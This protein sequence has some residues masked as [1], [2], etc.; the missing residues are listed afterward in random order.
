MAPATIKSLSGTHLSVKPVGAIGRKGLGF[1][2]VYTV[3]RTPCVFSQDDGLI[4]CPDRASAWLQEHGITTAKVPYQWLPFWLSRQAQEKDD[5]FLASLADMRTVVKLPVTKPAALPDVIEQLRALPGHS[6]LTF[7]KLKKLEVEVTEAKDKSFIVELKPRESHENEW[8]IE[9]TRQSQ[10][11]HW[12]LTRLPVTPPPEALA[13]FEDEDDRERAAKATILAATPLGEDNQVAPAPESMRL[14]VYYSTEEPAPVPLLLHAD[15]IVKSDRTRV[16]ALEASPFNSWMGERLAGHIVECV[17]QWYSAAA[18]AANLRLL[19]PTANLDDFPASARLWK[20]IETQAKALLRLPDAKGNRVLTL[21][22]ACLTATS[23]AP[24]LARQILSRCDYAARLVHLSLDRD[25]GAQLVLDKLGCTKLTDSSVFGAIAGATPVLPNDAEWLWTCWH[26]VA[27]WAVPERKSDWSRERKEQRLSLLRR[28][29]MLPIA[30]QTLSTQSLAGKTVTWREDNLQFEV[31]EWLPLLFIDDWLRDRVR[32]LAA[33]SPVRLLL[34]DLGVEQPKPEVALS[35]LGDAI[36]DYWKTK[37]GDPGRFLAYLLASNLHQQFDAL[38]SLERCPIRATIEGKPGEF[39]V[40]ARRAYFGQEWGDGALAELLRGRQGVAWATRPPG[41]PEAYRTLLTWLSVRE[42]PRLIPRTDYAASI[43]ERI[44]VYRRLPH[45]TSVGEIPA[46]EAL[47]GIELSKLDEPRARALLCLLVH[48]WPYYSSHTSQSISYRLRSWYWESVP[49]CWWE[50]LKSNLK[51][52][53]ASSYAPIPP[54]E[55]CWLPDRSTRRAIGPLLPIIDIES[56][57]QDKEAVGDWLM[58]QIGLRTQVA[59]VSLDE[60]RELLQTRIPALV[61]VTALSR[62]DQRQRVFRWYE[63][64]LDSLSAQEA[65]GSLAEVPL[66]CR[67][68]DEWSYVSQ[69]PRWLADDTELAEAFRKEIW[70]LTFPE[71]LHSLAKNHFGLSPISKANLEPHWDASSGED[72][73]KLQCSLEAVKPYLFAWKCY[74]SSQ[75]HEQLRALLQRLRVRTAN[76]LE[77][78]VTLGDSVPAKPVEKEVAII[79]DVLL[80]GGSRADLPLLAEAITLAVPPRSDADFYE[81]LLRCE[82]GSDRCRKLEASNFPLEQIQALLREYS[83]SG[84]DEE[85]AAGSSSSGSG[86]QERTSTNGAGQPAAEKHDEIAPGA[87]GRE[88][89]ARSENAGSGEAAQEKSHE[90]TITGPAS[91]ERTLSAHTSQ[92]HETT[93]SR[94]SKAP[95]TASGVV[96][97]GLSLKEPTLRVRIE[98]AE[99]QGEGLKPRAERLSGGDGTTKAAQEPTHEDGTSENLTQDQ[100]KAIE[101]RGREF[102]GLVLAKQMGYAVTQMPDTHPGYDLLAQKGEENLRVEVKAHLRTASVIDLTI[103]ELHEYARWKEAG[104]PLERWE[105]WNIEHLAGADE[106]EVIVTRYSDIPEDALDAKLLR[107]DLRKC[108]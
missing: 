77:A 38:A 54:L 17:A 95:A 69:Q 13:E 73:P 35:A 2:S 11:Q 47:D 37:Q 28:T 39:W 33:D 14:H 87:S 94:E 18:P 78:L 68:G 102:A 96:A 46:P 32:T 88:R 93:T 106:S 3:T 56:F 23:V 108:G 76:K 81:N 62:E 42:Y 43:N 83:A 7:N 66:L 60:W 49:S 92:E 19:M 30:G 6:L 74:K 9:D 53:L 70:Q 58:R 65:T 82:T 36:A 31:P 45:H 44:R 34:A 103:R 27:Q 51:P 61:P 85:E 4:F 90:A 101:K 57:K 107:V 29:P 105:L 8:S 26:W 97:D 67:R 52:P 100:K 79:G 24:E 20:N 59:Q 80:I 84:H 63:A 55:K 89:Q 16:V 64:C 41:N 10:R 98:N 21:A 91:D 75:E 48:H 71:R 1:K 72:S 15:F 99:R 12:R 40:E 104:R 50:E 22:D 86:E 25:E 5:P